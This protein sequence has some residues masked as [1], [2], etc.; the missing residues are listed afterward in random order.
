[1]TTSDDGLRT[2]GLGRRVTASPAISRWVLG[3]LLFG[4]T[5]LLIKVNWSAG[6]LSSRVI[7][8]VTLYLLLPLGFGTFYGRNVGWTINRQALRDTLLLVVLVAP[9]YVIGSALPTVRAYYPMWSTAPE[10]GTFLPHAVQLFVLALATETYY[11]GLLCVGV[12]EIGFKCVFISPIVYALMHTSKPPIELALSGPT[13]VLFGSVDFR[14]GSILPST[15]A[16]GC[17]LVL[18]DWLVLHDP[19]IAPDRVVNWLGWVPIPL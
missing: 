19:V 7:R 18:L 13:D 4:A 2:D 14:S 5:I 10:L 6:V 8:D 15:I 16:H 3:S 17:G 12:R 1:M 11:R 9:L